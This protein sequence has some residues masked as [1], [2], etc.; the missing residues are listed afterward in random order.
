MP[1]LVTIPISFFE[2]TIEYEK[3]DVRLLGD[4]AA[5]VQTIFEALSPFSPAL[6]DIEVLSAGKLSEQGVLFKLPQKNVSF[7]AG[8]TFCRFSRNAVNW[9][10]AKETIDILNVFVSTLT[11]VASVTMGVKKTAMGMHLQPR[12][13][14]FRDILRP[15]VPTQFVGL[16][17]ESIKTMGSI[18]RWEKRA[19]TIDG[20][21]SI[22]NGV[23]L[24]L[25]REFPSTMS[26]EDLA[27]QLFKDEKELFAIMGIEEDRQ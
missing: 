24:K 9:D 8:A 26:Y 5:M 25:E 2:V 16:E 4:R 27:Q 1:E 15:F 3:P 23:F 10:L 12:T 20:S 6:D 22:A 14:S 18:T 17:S 21:G 7:F 19:V 13:K 11:L